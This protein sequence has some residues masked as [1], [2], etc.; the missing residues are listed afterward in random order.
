[1]YNKYKKGIRYNNCSI[2]GRIKT[3]SE[4]ILKKYSASK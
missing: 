3:E 2:Y 4:H 1:M